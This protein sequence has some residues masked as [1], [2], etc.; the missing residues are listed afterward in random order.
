MAIG[1]MYRVKVPVLGNNVG[2]IGVVFNEY[3]DYDF[4]DLLG[5]QIIFPNGD[6]DGFSISEQV[7]LLEFYGHDERFEN[8]E[9][10]N[11]M[12]VSRDFQKGFWKFD[13]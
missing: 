12:Q 11:V 2:A 13:Q 4:P 1:D 5:F 3:P 8:Y 7:W 10:K 6:Y 9:F